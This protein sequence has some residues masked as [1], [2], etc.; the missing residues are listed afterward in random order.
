MRA[1][2]APLLF[3]GQGLQLFLRGLVWRLLHR[4]ATGVWGNVCDPVSMV[5]VVADGVLRA[6]HYICLQLNRQNRV[7]TFILCPCLCLFPFT[8]TP[9][10]EKIQ[11]A[12]ERLSTPLQTLWSCEILLLKSVWFKLIFFFFFLKRLRCVLG[13]IQIFLRYLLFQRQGQFLSCVLLV[14]TQNKLDLRRTRPKGHKHTFYVYGNY[15][16]IPFVVFKPCS[17][18]FSQPTQEVVEHSLT[19]LQ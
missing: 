3:L 4:G 12:Q 5:F 13:K 14:R 11:R 10:L 16:S 8:P 7:Q 6:A 1:Y 15:G 17:T 2:L 18:L 9:S 19:Y